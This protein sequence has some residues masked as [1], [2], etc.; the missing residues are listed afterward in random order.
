MNKK[1]KITRVDKSDDLTLGSVYDV[2][3]FEEDDILTPYR[4]VDDVGHQ[5]W[6][7]AS[8]CKLVEEWQP[9][10]GEMV[11]VSDNNIDWFEKKF[12]CVHN[13]SK[14]PFVV[15]VPELDEDVEAYKHIRQ[16]Q[17]PK[18]DIKITVNGEEKTLE[19]LNEI[20][21]NQKC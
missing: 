19:E 3:Y 11:E 12:I 6:V 10:Q 4:V 1:V 15:C 16:I 5:V 21:N 18:L 13:G 8:Q 17:K 2:I 20:V 9:V 7:E 14:H